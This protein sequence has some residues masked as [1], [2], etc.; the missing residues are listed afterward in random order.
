[1]SNKTD[2]DLF[3]SAC[4]RWRDSDDLL[5]VEFKAPGFTQRVIE[6]FCCLNGYDYY[7]RQVFPYGFYSEATAMVKAKDA[8]LRDEILSLKRNREGVPRNQLLLF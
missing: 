4:Y 6:A 3:F 7:N 1:M 5:A 8:R 2:F